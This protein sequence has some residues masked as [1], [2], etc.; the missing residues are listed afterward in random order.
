[1]KRFIIF[2]VAVFLISQLAIA[3]DS[4]NVTQLGQFDYCWDIATSVA[5]EETLAYV[6][7]G[8]FGTSLFDNKEATEHR[9]SE[10]LA[11]R[12]LVLLMLH[13]IQTSRIGRSQG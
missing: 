3:Q 5:V 13:P 2:L 12:P 7:T 9:C 8:G 11:W 4:L 1:M 6:A 10:R